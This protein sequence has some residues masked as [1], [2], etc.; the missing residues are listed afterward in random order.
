MTEQKLPQAIKRDWKWPRI[1]TEKNNNDKLT[2]NTKL[3]N[4]NR[5]IKS[6]HILFA[7]IQRNE[8]FTT[9][10]HQNH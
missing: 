2:I 4:D 8:K 5:I 9:A 1:E 7:H 3:I 6:T 10:R